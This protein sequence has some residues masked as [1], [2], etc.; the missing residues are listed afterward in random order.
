[1]EGLNWGF[2]MK[3][4]I[5][6]I[7]TAKRKCGLRILLNKSTLKVRKKNVKAFWEILAPA[8]ANKNVRSYV[9]LSIQRV[10][11]K[12]FIVVQKFVSFIS[13]GHLDNTVS[14]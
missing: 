2:A 14:H 12:M 4:F 3:V 11:D 10:L 8:I 1:M 13:L 6:K 9:L 7:K 5:F